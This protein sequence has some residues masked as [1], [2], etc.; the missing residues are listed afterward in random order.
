VLAT[1]IC[2]FAGHINRFSESEGKAVPLLQ[3]YNRGY[4]SGAGLTLLSAGEK[5]GRPD[6]EVPTGNVDRIEAQAE[7]A[8]ITTKCG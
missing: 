3:A 1:W 6:R 2:R 8:L 4:I 7:V 5:A